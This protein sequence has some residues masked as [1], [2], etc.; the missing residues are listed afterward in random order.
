MIRKLSFRRNKKNDLDE[1]KELGVYKTLNSREG[2]HVPIIKDLRKRVRFMEKLPSIY[3]D[4]HWGDD[5][6]GIIN[7][8]F[9]TYSI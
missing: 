4:I 6:I 1:L 9:D 5:L 3:V 8:I 7:D 2:P